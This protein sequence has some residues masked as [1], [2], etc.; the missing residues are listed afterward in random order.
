MTPTAVVFVPSAPLLVPEVAGGSAALDGELRVTCLDVVSRA[1]DSDPDTV[2]VVAPASAP[3]TWDEDA[4]WDFA[5]F[6][7]AREPTVDRTRLPWSLGIG[8]WLLDECG[9]TGRRRY[10]GVA[11]SDE[12]D[13][14]TDSMNPDLTASE[15][16]VVI[17]VADGSACRTERAPGHLDARAEGFD[18]GTADALSRGDLDALAAVEPALARELL[19]SG[20]P[21]W[22][23]L[24]AAIKDGPA[25][26]PELL[27]HVAPYGVAYFVAL[28]WF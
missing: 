24:R 6:G 21:V 1:L 4:S 11:G 22:R 17:A 3:A 2:V 28:W 25:A 15:R 26:R 14:V 23:W 8:A 20:L 13:S 9:W 19:C 12:R 7:V 16:C 10:V 27:T 5:G 18:D